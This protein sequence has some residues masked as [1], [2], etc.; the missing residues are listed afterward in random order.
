MRDASYPVICLTGAPATGKSTLARN[1]VMKFGS[2]K[3]FAYSE[4]LR[5][6]IKNKTEHLLSE[7]EIRT[8]SAT[9]VTAADVAALD[10]HLIQRV[11]SERKIAPFLID[12]HP[13][14]KEAYGFRV[15]GFSVDALQRLSPDLIICLY[16][17]AEVTI[18]RIGA[19]PMGRPTVTRFEA[20]MHT[21]LQTAVAAQYGVLLGRPVYLLD[22]SASR[23]SLVDQ[24]AAKAGLALS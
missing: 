14:T 6:F 4:E 13:V 12:S 23:E 21:Q 10:E 24:V 19:D 20:D 15:T 22:A 1:L 11:Q 3:L 18:E 16:A 5:H 7:D 9:V 17:S 2:T 8:R